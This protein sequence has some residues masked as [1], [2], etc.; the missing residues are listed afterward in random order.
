MPSL[1]QA[2]LDQLLAV[3]NANPLEVQKA[4]NIA[5]NFTGYD[6]SNIIF[7]Q[8]PILRPFAASVPRVQAAI[9]SNAIH[10]KTVTSVSV[11][12]VMPFV[13]EGQRNGQQVFTEVDRQ[14]TYQTMGLDDAVTDE[15]VARGLN[16]DD[17]RAR[18][19]FWLVQNVMQQEE[20]ALFGGNNATTGTALGTTPTPTVTSASTGGSIG[21]ITPSVI[22]VALPYLG[23]Q[24]ATRSGVLALLVTD[25]KGDPARG[26][27]AQKS[28][29]VAPGAITGT[30]VITATVNTSGSV[31]GV[32]NA[33]AYAWFVGAAGSEK[34]EAITTINSVRLTSLAGTG[35]AAAGLFTTDNSRDNTAFD[36]VFTQVTQGGYTKTLATGTAGTGTV[37]TTDGAGGVVEIDAVL[38]YLWNTY[39]LSPDK[40]H[41]NAQEAN[42]VNK[43]VVGSGGAS[44][45]RY[46]L[47]NT[48]ASQGQIMAASAVTTY[49]NKYTGQP[50]EIVIH[51]TITPGT[52]YF[53]TQTLP[54]W[55]PG[56]RAPAAW[57]VSVLKDYTEDV[58]GRTTRQWEH[59]VYEQ[60]TL[61]GWINAA[62]AYLTNIAPS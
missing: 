3:Q 25:S 60:I 47:A 51:P 19:S 11:A 9:G 31:T 54:M 26:T 28:A 24:K 2:T 52:I 53:Q 42:S 22:C 5:S 23:Y 27:Y 39:F 58:Y 49:F 36:G 10:W 1:T 43:L 48:P 13:S 59:G 8:Q 38:L 41:M 16:F 57:T 40:I 35:Q 32:V 15:A 29:A 14:A 61:Q 55:Y 17:V 56:T 44:I 21:A 50:V 62:Q 7:D 4:I 45:Y 12:G 20:P 37:M 33:Y 18:S 6:L 30:G 34:L 46:Q